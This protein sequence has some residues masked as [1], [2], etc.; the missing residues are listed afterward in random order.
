MGCLLPLVAVFAP[1]LT[2]FFIFIL[3]NWLGRAYETAIWP[4]LGFMF[5]PFTTLAYMATMLNN[6]HHCD[7]GWVVLIVVAAI[8]DL[9]GSSSAARGRN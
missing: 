8:C 9:G 6:N 4:I 7:G 3:T 1:R 5:M 2:L